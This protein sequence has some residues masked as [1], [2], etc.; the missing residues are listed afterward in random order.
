MLKT[1]IDLYTKTFVVWVILFGILAY[2]VPEPFLAIKGGMKW[3]FALTMFG[4]GVALEPADF[5]RIAQQPLLVF[6]GSVAQFTIMPFGA[7][8]IAYLFQL[9]QELAIGLILTGSAP[10]AM[11]S[12][13]MSYIA[14]ADV[15]YS[16]SLTTVSTLACPI[17]TPGL[18]KLLAGADMHVPFFAMM[19]DIMY[20]VVIPLLAGFAVR[21]VLKSYIEKMIFV[22]PA[23]STTFIIFIGTIVIAS[24]RNYLPLVTGIILVT[25]LILNVYGLTAG[26]LVG[27][28]FKME[29]SRK[30]ALAIEIGMQNAGL[31]T[32]LALEHF[33]ERAAAPAALFVFV[34]IITASIL[35]EWWSGRDNKKLNFS[36]FTE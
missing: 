10:G 2:F 3:F 13:V 26:Y 19:M 11:A 15:A 28:L 4:I 35:A 21:Y 34:C 33:G 31:G 27:Q 30:R 12:N 1:I 32:V 24:N 29:R 8:A 23:I 18:T 20:M 5:K 17:L 7:F 25:V 9:P 22:F 16:V 14:K 6:I 36:N